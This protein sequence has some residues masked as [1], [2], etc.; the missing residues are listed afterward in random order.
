[1][2][3]IQE[4]AP[5]AEYFAVKVF[6]HSLRTSA[7]QLLQ[8]IEWCIEQRMDVVNLS[9]G[10]LNPAHAER[11]REIEVRAAE[12]GT[13]L[14]AAREA[15]GQLCYPGCL[16]T[17]FS[18]GLDWDCPRN[19][20]RYET[21]GKNTVFY[22]SGYPRPA[23]GVPQARNLH[24]ISFAVANMTA[25]M[26]RACEVAGGPRAGGRARLIGDLLMR[27]CAAFQQ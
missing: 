7:N 19:R 18:V 27:E 12:T 16:P 1:M 2:A 15:D 24:G 23:P 21:N 9:L 22:A 25:F 26:A 3:A 6:H 14:V 11:F 5:A 13:L 8:A 20:Y 17:V 4:K 10:T